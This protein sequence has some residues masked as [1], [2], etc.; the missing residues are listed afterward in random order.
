MVYAV[1]SKTT[2]RLSVW[3]RLPPRPLN[4][5]MKKISPLLRPEFFDIFG[6]FVWIFFIV[7]SL[8]ALVTGNMPDWTLF[9]ILVIGVLGLIVDGTIVYKTYIRKK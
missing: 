1:V 4:I 9:V 2:A 6:V 8:R 7:V 5:V 3:V